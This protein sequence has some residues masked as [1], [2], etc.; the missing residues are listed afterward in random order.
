M[1]GGNIMLKSIEGIYRNGRIELNELP[2][3]IDNETPVIVTF[4][5]HKYIDLERYGISQSQAHQ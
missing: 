1:F 4:L 3:G 5:E 2:G